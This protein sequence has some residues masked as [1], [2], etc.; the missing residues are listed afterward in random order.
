[1]MTWQLRHAL[2]LTFCFGGWFPH[3]FYLRSVYK[4]IHKIYLMRGGKYCRVV[5]NEYYGEQHNT[6]ITITDLH[7]MNREQDRLT[8]DHEFLDS[9]G[10]M[11]HETAV[12]MDYFT[13]CGS[14]MNNEVIY[15]RT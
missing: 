14:P 7:L 15:F 4:K 9:E 1:M 10:K 6:W 8:D 12:Q 3:Y 13:Y 2:M 5:L 11:L